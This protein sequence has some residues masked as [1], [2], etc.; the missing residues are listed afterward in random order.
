MSSWEGRYAPLDGRDVHDTTMK[1]KA[2]TYITVLKQPHYPK[3]CNASVEPLWL[4]HV[5]ID[6]PVTS[7]AIKRNLIAEW[8][9]VFR[10][11]PYT[12]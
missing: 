8:E 3:A 7:K 12:R 2:I 1:Q 6:H 11:M 10:H 5:P 9:A 4:L